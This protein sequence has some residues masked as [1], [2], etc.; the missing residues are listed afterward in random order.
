MRVAVAYGQRQAEFDL[1]ERDLLPARR[2][3]HP[4]ALADPVGAMRAALET[5]LHFP[6]LRRALT[7]DDHVVIV[8]DERTPQLI[9]L[10]IPL[11]EH[12]NQA[13]VEPE[14]VTLLCPPPAT[15]QPWL[16]ELPEEF[17]NLRVEIHDPTDR[18]RLSYLATTRKGRRIYL[19]RTAIDADQV[20]VLGRRGYDPLT[21]YAGAE[22]A[23]F[24][25]LADGATRR[26][27]QKHLSLLPPGTTP[28]PLQRE[29]AEVAW[30]L[31]A[32]FFVHV[33][34][35]PDASVS[36]VLGGTLDSSAEGQHLLDAAWRVKVGRPADVVVAGLAGNRTGDE[37]ARLARALAN[38]ARVVKAEGRIVLLTES[39]PALGPAAQLLREAGDSKVALRRLST[40][41]NPEHTA[42]FEWASAAERA[43]IYLMSRLHSDQAEE[44]FTVP[45]EDP[46]QAQR[47]LVPG[48]SCAFLPEADKLMAE[49]QEDK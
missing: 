39:A 48:R 9:T 1:A 30:L 33:I 8:L 4:A 45:L 2:Q 42:A 18:D 23:L 14:A 3:R 36:H 25:A 46:G 26:D 15:D 37:F 11:L 43:T 19:N 38:A 31:G 20:V 6:P 47:L 12:L 49:V 29:A 13:H 24:P 21:G 7:P 27:V 41:D 32:P 22:T 35:G 5:P 16:E 34:T 28:W 44:L 10:L 40:E 17:E